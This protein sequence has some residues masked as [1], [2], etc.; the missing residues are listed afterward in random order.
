MAELNL[1]TA[2]DLFRHSVDVVMPA[3]ADPIVKAAANRLRAGDAETALKIV[4]G[5]V[6]PYTRED[7]DKV[8]VNNLSTNRDPNTKG[9]IAPTGASDKDQERRYTQ[10]KD[11]AQKTREL[12]ESGK[13]DASI[14]TEVRTYLEK[15]IPVVAEILKALPDDA[16]RNDFVSNLLSQAS[17]REHLIRIYNE[18]LNPNKRLT[19]EE[20]VRRLESEIAELEF[21]IK[22]APTQV[23]LTQAQTD[24]NNAK[25]AIAAKAS[26]YEMLKA[27]KEELADRAVDKVDIERGVRKLAPGMKPVEKKVK[28][29]N[30]NLNALQKEKANLEAMGDKISNENKDRLKSINDD[31]LPKVETELTNYM[32]TREGKVYIKYLELKSELTD[33]ADLEKQVNDLTTSLSPLETNLQTAQRTLDEKVQLARQGLINPEQRAQMEAQLKTKQI[34][35]ADT[36]AELDAEMIKF[37]RD[38]AHMPADAMESFLSEAFTKMK[39]VWTEEAQKAA[40]KETGDKNRE[41]VDAESAL[42]KLPTGLWKEKKDKG[43]EVTTKPNKDMAKQYMNAYLTG[44]EEGL[45]NEIEKQFSLLGK[46]PDDDALKEIGLNANEIAAIKV[47]VKDP[48]F[49]KNQAKIIA[50]ELFGDYLIAGGKWSRDLVMSLGSSE[51]GRVLMATA[52][53]RR[54]EVKKV[55]GEAVGKDVLSFWDQFKGG[56]TGKEFLAANWWKYLMIILI[57]VIGVGALIKT[58]AAGAGLKAAGLAG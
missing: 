52:E 41:Q 45:M 27:L 8:L 26:D 4:K 15:S 33:I 21:K 12:A 55:L 24:F 3:P 46:F 28:D 11:A 31:L 17:Y 54:G 58:G 51:Q 57:A 16:S 13:I 23:E 2:T 47:K 38:V 35:L 34:E 49:R 32:E 48:E 20:V 22:A 25:L 10:T 30:K 42:K 5:A 36:R 50:A 1:A 9:K 29:L 14:I 18:T 56:K 40:D 19:K 39:T 43:G 44:G 53:A 37:A 6:I 7:A